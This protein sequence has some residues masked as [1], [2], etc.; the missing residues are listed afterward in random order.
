MTEPTAS[1]MQQLRGSTRDEHD[2]AEHHQFQQALVR[3]ELP[4]QRYEAW[5]GQMYLIHSSLEQAL[6]A[7]AADSEAI[8]AVVQDYQY[9]V[10]YLL[11]DLQ[12]F[13]VD[14]QSI[15]PLPSTERFLA[16][17]A[18]HA[19]DPL[20]LLGLH[21]VLEGSN[22]GGR[23]IARHVSQ[24]YQLT[25]GPGLRYL[26]P[27]DDRQREYWMA[28]R[29]TMDSLGLADEEAARLVAAAKQMYGTVAELSDDLAAST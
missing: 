10:P 8:R 2:R 27:Y 1:A 25:P 14:P 4:R 22:N 13:G 3:G 29:E 7:A 20:H 11:E 18:A 23:F 5:L 21:Y 9:Q 15:V 19:D 26:D 28:F 12:F 17:V 16:M 24:A 6:Q